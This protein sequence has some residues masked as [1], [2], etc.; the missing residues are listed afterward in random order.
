MSAYLI[1]NVRIVDGTGR[2]PFPGAVAWKPSAS[3]PSRRAPRLPG[4]RERQSSTGGER[5]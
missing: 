5:P 4:A 3:L 2:E 1:S